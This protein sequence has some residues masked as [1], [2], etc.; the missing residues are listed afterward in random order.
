MNE[1]TN[2]HL[3]DILELDIYYDV[4]SGAYFSPKFES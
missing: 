1:M 3:K 4:I 2:G